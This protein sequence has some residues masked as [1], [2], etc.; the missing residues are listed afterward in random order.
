MAQWTK[1]SAIA[2]LQQLEANIG[3]LKNSRRFSAEH[4]RWIAQTNVLFEEVFGKKSLY[5]LSFTAL[6]WQWT[7][8][9]IIQGGDVNADIEAHHHQAY[10]NHLETAKG[11][12]LAACDHLERTDI[13]SVYEGKDTTPEASAIIKVIN[14]AEHS[15]RKATHNQPQNEREVQDTFENLLLGAEISY[16]REN[17]RIE[18]SS[19]TYTPDFTVPK[20]ELA[21][22]IKF[23]NRDGR[24][25]EIIA[26]I[27]DDILAYQTKYGNLLFVIYDLGFIRDVERFAVEFES[28]QNVV[29][30]V[31]K[32]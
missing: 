19:K 7:G 27:N 4:T 30:R 9:R 3:L 10:L 29:V 18:Y 11:L 14:L 20:I 5:Y 22:E 17:D 24:E 32:H 23:C 8:S 26:E 2:A 13:T 16:S 15:L 6:K 31:V 12:L 1:E 21:I 28:Q 25:K